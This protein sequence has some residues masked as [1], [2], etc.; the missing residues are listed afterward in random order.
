MIRWMISWPAARSVFITTFSRSPE[1]TLKLRA[2]LASS[3]TR[4]IS[5]S[6]EPGG[7]CGAMDSRVLTV[8]RLAAKHRSEHSVRQTLSL[9]LIYLG[10]TKGVTKGRKAGERRMESRTRR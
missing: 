4:F 2:F 9:W 8:A 7:V 1:I 10:E 3:E 6:S 5:E